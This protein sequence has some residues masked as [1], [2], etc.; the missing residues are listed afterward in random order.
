MS[1]STSWLLPLRTPV[2]EHCF[3]DPIN[4]LHKPHFDASKALVLKY[5]CPG[6]LEHVDKSDDREHGVS[7]VV[8]I[9][10]KCS[11]DSDI[12]HRELL[13]LVVSCDRL[14]VDV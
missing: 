9:C 10:D 7:L 3:S 4:Y 6:S 2:L 8:S 14:G 1:H 12:P 13:V 5:S 11:T